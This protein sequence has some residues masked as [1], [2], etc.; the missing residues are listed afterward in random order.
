M[1]Y[2]EEASTAEMNY[3][4]PVVQALWSYGYMKRAFSGL[5][6]T[7]MSPA[8]QPHQLYLAA[9]HTC[10]H[11]FCRSLVEHTNFLSTSIMH[12]ECSRIFTDRSTSFH[13][14]VLN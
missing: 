7:S 3:T 5:R 9:R 13:S 10:F 1:S 4:V 8:A 14:S 11:N 2:P 12:I 6:K